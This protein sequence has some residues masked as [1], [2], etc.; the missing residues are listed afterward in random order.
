MLKTSFIQKV[1]IMINTIDN[2]QKNREELFQL[3]HLFIREDYNPDIPFNLQNLVFILKTSNLDYHSMFIEMN[4]LLCTLLEY[5]RSELL[6]MT[7]CD[8]VDSDCV[9][10][11]EEKKKKLSSNE[12]IKYEI[13]LK[14]KFGGKI[15]LEVDSCIFKS[16]DNIIE[17]A[18]AKV[19]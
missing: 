6:D 8:L 17:F 3:K 1:V 7:L 16:E 9:A 12:L 11:L 14:K 10:I 18:V 19:K 5:S 4:D 15:L 2:I 13:I